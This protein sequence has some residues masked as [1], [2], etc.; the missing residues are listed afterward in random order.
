MACYS[1][2]IEQRPKVSEGKSHVAIW[3]KHD[4]GRGSKCL[5]VG[6]CLE[7][8]QHSKE[9]SEAQNKKMEGDEL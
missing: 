2:D 5:E 1:G 6:I 3:G 8:L 7:Y 4:L 9:D